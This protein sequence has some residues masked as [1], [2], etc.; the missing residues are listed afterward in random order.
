MRRNEDYDMGIMTVFHMVVAV[1]GAYM[2]GA[3]LGMKK[4][5]KVSSMV[6]AE[7]ELRRCR[8]KQ[9]FIDYLYWKEAVFGGVVL[10]AGVLGIIN[11]LVVSLGAFRIVQMLLF[12]AAFLWFQSE[13]RKAREKF[14]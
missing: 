7:E 4:S 1:F 6:I 5:G 3:A 11:D 13:L 10:L 12:L 2:I 14:L 9:S 8:D